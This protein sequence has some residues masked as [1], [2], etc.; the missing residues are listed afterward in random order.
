[1]LAA[2]SDSEEVLEHRATHPAAC[3][4][5]PQ[6]RDETVR[7]HDPSRERGYRVSRYK[8]R[9]LLKSV[10]ARSGSR[11]RAD[12]DGAAAELQL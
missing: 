10:N 2:T 11:A 12:D 6:P 8:A 4:T 7:S 5:R 9:M 1:M 3:E